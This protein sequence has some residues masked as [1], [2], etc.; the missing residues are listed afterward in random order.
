M[1]DARC[2][3]NRVRDDF[4]DG[5]LE[6][7][8]ADAQAHLRTCPACR[9][10][11]DARRV[12]LEGTASTWRAPSTS[13][14]TRPWMFGVAAAAAAVALLLVVP[15]RSGFRTKG[16]GL[17]LELEV[18]AGTGWRAWSGEPLHP[19]DHLR[20]A[21]GGARDGWALVVG[22]EQSGRRFVYA[23]SDG[24][25]ADVGTGG[26]IGG[27]VALDDSLGQEQIE[28]IVCPEKFV[29][30]DGARRGAC[31]RRAIRVV[32]EAR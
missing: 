24:V 17:R 23:P 1:S 27:P 12:A 8:D 13:R 19:G 15:S 28:V 22:V 11:L 21:V 29:F 20:F 7:I 30:D 6:E 18:D 31:V 32:K 3:S 9:R 25:A 4:Q 16:S 10:Y 14:V 5:S 26:Y 2:P